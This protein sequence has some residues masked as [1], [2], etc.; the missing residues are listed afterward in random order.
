MKSE[1][2]YNKIKRKELNLQS[3]ENYYMK[4]IKFIRNYQKFN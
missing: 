4:S 3:K 2:S 1:L